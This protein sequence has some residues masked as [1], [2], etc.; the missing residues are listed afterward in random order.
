MRQAL[1]DASDENGFL[2]F[3][4]F[5]KTAL[6]HPQLG[7]YQ[8]SKQ[9]VGRDRD[10]D[11]YTSSSF[12]NTFTQVL[13][14]ASSKLLEACSLKTS[15][16]TWIEIGSEPEAALL[17]GIESPFKETKAF[18]LNQKLELQGQLVVFSNELFDAQPFRSVIFSEG[19]WQERGFQISE[20]HF[21]PCRRPLANSD[22]ENHQPRLPKI[23]PE[24]YAVDLPT[25]S[26]ELLDA[27]AKQDWTGIFIAFD[28]GKTWQTLA[29]DTPQGT[30]RAYVNH[31]QVPIDPALAGEQDITHHLCWE[32][33]E[34]V[35]LENGFEN[36]KLQSQEAF[37]V[38]L[39]SDFV[40]KTIERAA[41]S[42]SRTKSQLRE[43][44]HPSLMGQKFQALTGARL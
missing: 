42:L 10:S 20:G 11:F 12:R 8:K 44:I 41:P 40:R 17:C 19:A 7:Y 33:L 14:E 16:T 38:K 31:Q 23:A 34:A 39:A 27:I 28:Y 25:G 15:E 5:V 3:S 18:E 37:I 36:I 6:Y 35:L 24:G 1:E 32:W 43:L 13:I 26:A 2:D 4:S 9:R 29:Y 21:K 22:L 30:A